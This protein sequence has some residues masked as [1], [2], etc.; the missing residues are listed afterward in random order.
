MGKETSEEECDQ[1]PER[2]YTPTPYDAFF[3]AAFADPQSAAD[4]IRNFLPESYSRRI[5][6]A[7]V[8]VDVK[9]YINRYLTEHQSDLLV[10]CRNTEGQEFHFY[11][12]YEHKSSPERSALLLLTRAIIELT[13]DI[14]GKQTAVDEEEESKE[15]GQPDTVSGASTEAAGSG[16]TRKK[17]RPATLPAKTGK[18]GY[19]WLPEIIPVILYHGR[20]S[21]NY[22]T[23]FSEQIDSMDRNAGHLLRFEPFFI[24]LQAYRDNQFTG[25]LKTVVGLMV[26]KYLSRRLDREAA[27]R[28]VGTMNGKGSVPLY[29]REFYDKCY[30]ALFLVKDQKE[31]KLL[32]GE[33]E[34]SGY[35]EEKERAM[36]YA[37]AAEKKGI[38]RGLERGK[39]EGKIE[40]EHKTLIRQ[41]DRKFGLS[42]EEKELVHSTEELEKIEAALDEFVF[43]ERKEQVLA[44]LK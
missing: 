7:E 37:E 13:F 30:R 16:G 15:D 32:L 20:P 40:G 29:L 4:L 26:L 23:Q 39:E 14:L 9:D 12:L 21:W 25:S 2:T 17:W 41:L 3:K 35:T 1:K 31:Y 34:K 42:E 19:R 6:G 28:L 8:S 36:T 5:K 22:P 33:L 43:A 44:H 18:A 38:E 24:R 27:R 10:T 11:F